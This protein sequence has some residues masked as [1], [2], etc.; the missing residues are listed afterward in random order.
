MLTEERFSQILQLLEKK[1]AVTVAQFTEAL[2]TSESTIRRDLNT[3]AQYGK[4]KKVHGGAT[5]IEKK[6]VTQEENVLTKSLKNIG[7]KSLLAEYGASVISNEDFVFLDA[8][9]TTE[10]IIDFLPEGIAATFVTNGIVHAKKLIQR[11]FKAYVIGGQLKLS[12]EAV[13]G[14]Q[15][16]NQL[17]GFNFTKA[18]LGTN[19]I[20]LDVGFSTPDI[21]E[22]LVKQ[23]VVKRSFV[24]YVL[25]DSSK[26]G[27]ISSVSYAEISQ[28]CIVTEVEPD[29][30]YLDA[31]VVKVIGK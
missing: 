25:A 24:S 21:E 19:G 28:C 18:F 10:K 12:T 17:R 9:T 22:A 30:K 2:G 1:K 15:A 29:E 4:L 20:D 7:E 16:I 23:E 13:V 27:N 6:A 5:A 14:A 26:F 8:G 11:G 3:L 31:T